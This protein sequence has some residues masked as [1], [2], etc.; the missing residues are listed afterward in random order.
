MTSAFRASLLVRRNLSPKYALEKG[1]HLSFLF[2]RYKSLRRRRIF[3]RGWGAA[4]IISS[5]VDDRFVLSSFYSHDFCSGVSLIPRILAPSVANHR[6]LRWMSRL[7]SDPLGRRF[8]VVLVSHYHPFLAYMF[9]SCLCVI[10]CPFLKYKLF[11]FPCCCFSP[12]F[13][14]VRGEVRVLSDI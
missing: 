1:F 14:Y 3:Y 5:V 13:M 7:T 4:G 8:A 11:C 2:K 9:R 10:L 6:F 12:S